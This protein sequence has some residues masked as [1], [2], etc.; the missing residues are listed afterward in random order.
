MQELK[1]AT[2]D[3]ERA[4]R[5]FEQVRAR[6]LRFRRQLAATDQLLDLLERMNLNGVQYLGGSAA[7]RIERTLEVL[8]PELRLHVNPRT[9]VQ[10]ALDEVFE[11]QEALFR[12]LRR[13][14]L[15]EQATALTA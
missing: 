11:I 4:V 6:R 5:E 15:P 7:R 3:I 12:H 13:R 8:P 1:A 2:N 9:R 14:G 10:R